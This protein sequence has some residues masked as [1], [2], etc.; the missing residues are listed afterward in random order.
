M[1]LQ[2]FTHTSADHSY[3]G[4]PSIFGGKGLTLAYTPAGYS[5]IISGVNAFLPFVTRSPESINDQLL[6]GRAG[7]VFDLR[8]SHF[9][10]P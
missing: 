10:E 5:S 8:M 3:V 2:V 1:P 4:F 7:L 6:A 9:S